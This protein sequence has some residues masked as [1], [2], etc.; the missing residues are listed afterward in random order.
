MMVGGDRYV[1]R[2][3]FSVSEEETLHRQ[4]LRL[5]S[6]ALEW[7]GRFGREQMTVEELANALQGLGAQAMLA[8]H[9]SRLVEEPGLSPCLEVLQ[10]LSS[11]ETEFQ[12]QLLRYGFTSFYDDYKELE[13]ALARLRRSMLPDAPGKARFIEDGTAIGSSTTSTISEGG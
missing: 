4:V 8:K 12:F 2:D 13:Q 10:L 5:G 11:L 9:W 1:M 6:L 7:L 3:S